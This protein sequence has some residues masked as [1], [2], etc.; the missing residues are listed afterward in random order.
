MAVDWKEVLSLTSAMLGLPV[1]SV[2]VA[3]VLRDRNRLKAELLKINADTRVQDGVANNSAATTTSAILTASTSDVLRLTERL[4]EMR[5]SLDD[6]FSQ[7]G[8]LKLEVTSLKITNTEQAAQ[9][10]AARRERVAFARLA[11]TFHKESKERLQ[12]INSLALLLESAKRQAN[13]APVDD[14]MPRAAE[15]LDNFMRA[16]DPDK[17]QDAERRNSHVADVLAAMEVAVME[18]RVLSKIREKE[19]GGQPAE[20][21]ATH[22]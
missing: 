10:A 7:I 20:R 12:V 4:D 22:T 2:V 5:R 1:A 11:L 6:A 19:D 17:V 21:D 3:Y 8:G 18:E 16:Y 15:I 14:F 9:L 13:G